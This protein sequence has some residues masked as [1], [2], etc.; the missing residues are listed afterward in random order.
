[1]G[2]CASMLQRR[3]ER[4]YPEPRRGTAEALFVVRGD[5]RPANPEALVVRVQDS[6]RTQLRRHGREESGGRGGCWRQGTDAL[7]WMIARARMPRLPCAGTGTV[8]VEPDAALRTRETTAAGRGAPPGHG[9]EPD[10]PLLTRKTTAAAGRGAPPGTRWTPPTAPVTPTP[11]S[12]AMTPMGGAPA[13]PSTPASAA[14][15]PGRPVWQ[16]RILMGMR[17]ELPRF[18]GLVLYDEHGRPI[19]VGTPGRRNHRQGKKKTARTSSTT[20][21]RDLL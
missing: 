9:V 12:P 6:G 17:C 10:A 5:R 2:L 3:T 15:T 18:S 21:L 4:R 20:T 16:R 8:G 19:Q 14:M 11:P 13:A 7:D 1:M